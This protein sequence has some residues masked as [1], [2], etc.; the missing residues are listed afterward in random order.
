M[1]LVGG[2]AFLVAAAVGLAHQTSL[3][4]LSSTC[5]T[6]DMSVVIFKVCKQDLD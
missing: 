6:A 1:T 5:L 2:H 4:F 3:A